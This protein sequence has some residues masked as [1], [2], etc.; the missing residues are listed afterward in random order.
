[1]RNFSRVLRLALRYRLTLMASLV[2]ALGVA[3]LWGL[4]IGTIYPFVKVA[5][6]RKSLQDWI[7]EELTKSQ[8]AIDEKAAQIT[9]YESLLAL[10]SSQQVQ[11]LRQW[12]DAEGNPQGPGSV[13]SAER[14]RQYRALLALGSSQRQRDLQA[15]IHLAR[16]RVAAEREA[17][18]L[19]R[20]LQP[21]VHRYLPHDSFKTLVL[22]IAL[23]LV[24]TM[25]KV[26]FLIGN[27]VL[28][29]RLAQLS[30]FKLRKLFYRRTLRMGLAT[31]SGEGTADLMSRFTH[32]MEHVAV[33]LETLF[34]KL[35]REPLK[36]AACLIGAGLICWRL[37]ILSL[38]I[39]PL[40]ALLIRWLAR[41]LKRANRRAME[42]MAQIYNA[43]EETFRGIRVVKAFTN[44]RQERRR[45]HSRSKQYYR[46]S[47]RIAWYNALSRPMTEVMGIVTICLA[48]M[49]GAWLVLSRQ[50]HLL[51]IRMSPRPLS[52]ELL[53]LFYGLLAGAADPIRKLSEVFSHLQRAAAASD[54][55]FDRLDREP[56]IRDPE[57]PVPLRRHRQD[58]VFEGVGFAYQSGPPVLEDINLRIGFGRTVAIVGPN[59]CGKST[60]A[61]LIPRF[62]DPTAGTIRLD[63]VP[64]ADLRLRGLRCQIG[65]V[66]QETL[67]FDDTVFN[68]IRYGAP[69]ASHDEVIEAA[70]RAHAHAFIE[71][72]LPQ[73]YQT[74][75]GPT[76]SRLS[77]GQRQRVAL[78]R[79]ILRDP[80][81]LIL[82]EPTSQVDVESEQAIRKVLDEFLAH[83]TAVIITHRMA[84]LALADEIVV[85]QSGRIV[86]TGSHDELLR[87]CDLY[88]RLYQIQLEEPNTTQDP[89]LAA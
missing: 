10:E 22:I 85:M 40:A 88:R 66:T 26:V 65:L 27:N 29:A 31:F 14:L 61:S 84:I 16:S 43:L 48:L 38:L 24:G 74:I 86:D 62:Y 55:I 18:R 28:V 37:L 4:N 7:D 78:A 30:T 5:F 67:L 53:L 79:A 71:R 69:R 13:E 45:F 1:M 63:G 12:I 60:L 82:D 83:R 34:G 46:R 54:R 35:V 11:S 77:G 52:P 19:S 89:P 73:G 76:G 25:V 3:I 64:L 75:V 9:R 68:N 72:Q 51:G 44:E 17:L 33:G 20:R 21:Y 15:E 23:V 80:D 2:C 49:A 36:M 41:M 42:E 50:T 32:D 59:G 87:R 39:A 47:M 58:L 57:H 8:Q 6:Q 70:K 56:E 81:I